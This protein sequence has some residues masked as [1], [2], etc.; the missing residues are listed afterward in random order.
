MKWIL[1]FAVAFAVVCAAIVCAAIRKK[2]RYRRSQ[3]TT[4]VNIL[5]A[6]TLVASVTIFLPIYFELCRQED[7]TVVDAVLLSVHNMMRL[8]VMDGEMSFIL[9]NITTLPPWLHDMYFLLSAALFIAAPILTLGVVLSLFDDLKAHFRFIVSRKKNVFIFSELNDC[10][11]ALAKDID[12]HETDGF[13]VFTDVYKEDDEKDFELRE[14]AHSLGAVCMQDDISML[15]LGKNLKKSTVRFFAIGAEESE[16]I[17]QAIKLIEKHNDRDDTELYV[18]SAQEESDLMLSTISEGKVRVRKIS[19]IRAQVYRDLYETGDRFFKDAKEK[20]GGRI[21]A[22]IVGLGRQGAEYLKTL[23]WFCQMD[24]YQLHIHGFDRREDTVSRIRMQ[25][26]EL[27]DDR[28]NCNFSD[29]G[30]AQ[31][32]LRFHAGLDVETAEFYDELK[33]VGSVT[34]VLVALG[35]DDKNILV[36]T[37]LRVFFERQ[38]VHPRI[39]AIVYDP[40]KKAAIESARNFSGQEYDIE[41]IGD[42]L[43]VYTDDVII[44]SELESEA[45]KRHLQWG[46]EAGFWRFDY[47]RKSS[48]AS[49]L[50]KHAKL[51]CRISGAD[52]PPEDRSPEDRVALRKLEHRRW[53]AYMRSEGFVFSGS[54]AKTSRNDLGKM[55]HCLVTFDDL[56][57]REKEKDDD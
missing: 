27:V 34:Y 30:E 33:T 23:T 36:A 49:A 55:H 1:C 24:G 32:E 57:E 12:R 56:P 35:D 29:D 39:Q 50:H 45:L 18:L 16:N 47:N 46:D 22:V 48:M 25:C 38:G 2:K 17:G 15:R 5:F 41:Y 21:T 52:L 53:N 51:A 43:S 11:I 13:F 44:N 10:S 6:G 14:E 3:L 37:S 7:L 28:Y 4:P 19:E 40:N 26:P 42:I 31:Y 8:F 20:T 54:T 9:D